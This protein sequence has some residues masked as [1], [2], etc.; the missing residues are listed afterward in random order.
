[1]RLIHVQNDRRQSINALTCNIQSKGIVSQLRN[2]PNVADDA[3]IK[4]ALPLFYTL[5]G[6]RTQTY[7]RGNNNKEDVTD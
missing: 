5:Y 4:D 2:F 6:I 7:T 1:M 3:R